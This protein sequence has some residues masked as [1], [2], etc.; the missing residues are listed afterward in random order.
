MAGV[1]TLSYSVQKL[2]FD[3]FVC[4]GIAESGLLVSPT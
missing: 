4:K 2:I 3:T 1:V